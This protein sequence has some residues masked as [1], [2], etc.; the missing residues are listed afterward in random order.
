MYYVMEARGVSSIVTADFYLDNRF[1]Y[2][3]ISGARFSTTPPDPLILT[4]DPEHESGVRLPLYGAGMVLMSKPLVGALEEAGIDNLDKYPVVIRSTVGQ[5]DCHDYWAVNI[6]GVISAVDRANS[7]IFD[8]PDGP[9]ISVM[10]EKLALDESKIKG[11]LL[12]RLAESVG[13]ILVHELIVKHLQSKGG[14]KLTFI[15]SADYCG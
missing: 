11:Q 7:I 2:S 3:W 8:E 9:L 14:F 4:W 15:N 5:P 12:F 1:P 10:F 13:T 6:I